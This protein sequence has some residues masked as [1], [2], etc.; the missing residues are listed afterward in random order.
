MSVC[1]SDRTRQGLVYQ[2]NKM[3]TKFQAVE[4][5]L[6]RWMPNKFSKPAVIVNTDAPLC[7]LRCRVKTLVHYNVMQLVAS[8]PVEN[9]TGKQGHCL[10]ICVPDTFSF[11][12]LHRTLQV[13]RAVVVDRNKNKQSKYQLKPPAPSMCFMGDF[14][15]RCLGSRAT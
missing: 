11:H 12:N 6:F 2:C 1:W 15:D 10:T 7:T 5:Y 14:V 8:R 9:D 13:V 3:Q 4:G